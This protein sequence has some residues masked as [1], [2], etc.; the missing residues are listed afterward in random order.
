M[1]LVHPFSGPGWG[2]GV[3]THMCTHCA[4]ADFLVIPLVKLWI[5]AASGLR[6]R[7]RMKKR[8]HRR[9]KNNTNRFMGLFFFKGLKLSL[10]HLA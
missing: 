4:F 6:E 3:G 5:G 1:P 7:N 8:E 9:V 2:R 10:G